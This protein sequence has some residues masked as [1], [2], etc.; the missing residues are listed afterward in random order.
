MNDDRLIA[1]EKINYVYA[2]GAK[3][4]RALRDVSLAIHR[5]DFAAITGPSGS[6]KSTLLYIMGLMLTPVSGKYLFDGRDFLQEDTA[7]KEEFRNR[8]LGFVFQKFNL[9]P[10]VSA[11]DNVA[12][13]LVYSGVRKKD[14]HQRA[15]ELLHKVGLGDRLTHYPSELS[16]GEQQRVA[17]ARALVNRPQIILADEP[18]GNLDRATGLH[19]MNIF[20]ELVRE[21]ITVVVVSHDTEMVQTAPRVIRMVDGEVTG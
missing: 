10:R 3:E 5:G 2:S 8:F 18:T 13:P 11:L 20:K 19:I 6:G 9:L 14:R 21:G 12:L 15:G 17:I 16:G 1:L 4:V 7:V